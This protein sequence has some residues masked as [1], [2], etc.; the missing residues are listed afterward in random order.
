MDK[1]IVTKIRE[2]R[3]KEKE[4]QKFIKVIN[5]KI[6]TNWIAQKVV[7]KCLKTQFCYNLDSS[8]CKGGGW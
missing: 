8:K 1:T 2:G 3:W 5:L 4:H 6:T 7:E